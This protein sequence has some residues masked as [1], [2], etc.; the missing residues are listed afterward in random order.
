MHIRSCQQGQSSH[1]CPNMVRPK[2]PS[3]EGRIGLSLGGSNRLH[4]RFG[5]GYL[6]PRVARAIAGTEALTNKVWVFLEDRH[7]TKK[8]GSR[9]LYTI[10]SV[11]QRG[12]AWSSRR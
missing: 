1:S 9:G 5:A 3:P 7:R 2:T 6:G 4:D 8:R 10:R 11:S 12:L